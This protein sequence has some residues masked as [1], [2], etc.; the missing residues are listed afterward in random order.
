MKALIAI[1]ILGGLLMT[2]RAVALQNTSTR[3]AFLIAVKNGDLNVVKQML[4]ED[5]SLARAKDGNGISAILKATYFGRKEVADLLLASGIELNIFEASATGQADR[6]KKL[7]TGDPSLTNSFHTDGFFPLG[8]AT[9]FGHA[10]TVDVL[11]AA[12]ADVNL[13]SR[14]SMKVSALQSAV[15]SGRIDIARKLIGKGANVNPR[16]EGG[17]VPLHEAAAKGD[18]EFAKLLL[19]NGADINAKSDDG[20]TPL[21]FAMS[22]K[23]TAMID[24]LRQRGAK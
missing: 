4:K 7:V 6:V 2:Q 23:K 3:E 19:D 9:F 18:L 5:A 24:F 12:G 13:V 11:L 14:E 21:A 1:L 10:D 15:A 16:S 22:Q 17:F 20:K 8:L